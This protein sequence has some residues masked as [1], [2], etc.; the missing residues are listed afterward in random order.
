M[1]I[2]TP[3][4]WLLCLLS[5]FFTGNLG[6]QA[7]GPFTI[8]TYERIIPAQKG[9]EDS[10]EKMEITLSLADSK[11]AKLGKFISSLLYDGLTA[12]GYADKVIAKYSKSYEEDIREYP[13]APPWVLQQEY[14]ESHSITINGSYAIITRNITAFLGGPHPNT[15]I[16]YYVINTKTPALIS[17]N[18]NFTQAGFPRL[19]SIVEQKVLLYLKSMEAELFT[20]EIKTENFRPAPEGL[21]FY[22]NPYELTAYAYGP[23]EITVTWK[24]LEEFLSPAGKKLAL[25]Y[26]K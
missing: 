1:K 23:V 2:K 7:I 9:R 3:I 5:V 10:K 21:V 14:E 16:I 11:Q 6:A 18:D 15:V 20:S 12:K 8:T 25:A 13:D 24:E 4:M 17:I 26:R 19:Q 22:W